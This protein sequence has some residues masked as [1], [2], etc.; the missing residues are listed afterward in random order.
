MSDLN[1][2]TPVEY[3]DIPNQPGYRIGTDQ[4]VWSRWLGCPSPR[5]KDEWHKLKSQRLRDGHIKVTLKGK[6]ALVHRLMLEA[7]VGPCPPGMQCRHIDGNPANNRIENL[8]WGTRSENVM[9]AVR[10]GTH[11]A[12][13]CKGELN[14]SAK[15][16]TND[17]RQIRALLASKTLFQREIGKRFGVCA[18]TIGAIHRGIIWKHVT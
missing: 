16:A 5:L 7:F 11:G 10:H 12:L 4:S 1:H 18:N 9:D 13:K 17:V 14:T 2:T 15:L 3:L 8:A 6:A